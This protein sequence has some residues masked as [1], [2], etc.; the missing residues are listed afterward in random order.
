MTCP[1]GVGES[2]QTIAHD[3]EPD[4]EKRANG[5][6]GRDTLAEVRRVFGE[7]TG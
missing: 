6:C 3:V 5:G 4:A 1:C 7:R 2:L